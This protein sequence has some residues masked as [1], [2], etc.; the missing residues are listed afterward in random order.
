M[1]KT[2]GCK[3]NWKYF[4]LVCNLQCKVT[5]CQPRMGSSAPGV[6]VRITS[7][8]EKDGKEKQDRKITLKFSSEK[9]V[10]LSLLVFSLLELGKRSSKKTLRNKI[11]SKLTFVFISNQ[12]LWV[13]FRIQLLDFSLKSSDANS[14]WSRRRIRNRRYSKK[15]KYSLFPLKSEMCGWPLNGWNASS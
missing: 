9:N 15:Y 6:R 10:L 5:D 1:R 2:W 8:R 14:A 11:T 12:W 4:F 7:Q 13:F 3:E